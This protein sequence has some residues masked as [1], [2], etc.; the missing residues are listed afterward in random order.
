MFRS[1]LKKC[2]VPEKNKKE[3]VLKWYKLMKIEEKHPISNKIEE[4]TKN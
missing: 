4:L 3:Q 2:S 1:N